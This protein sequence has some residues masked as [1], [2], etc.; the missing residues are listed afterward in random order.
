MPEVTLEGQ[1]KL[2]ASKVLVVGTGGLGSPILAYLSAAGIGQ[3]GLVDFDHVD[4]TNLQ[5][6]I[7]HKT[8][9]VGKPKTASAIET[10]REINP[11]VK[12]VPYETS[13]RSDNAIEIAKEYDVILDGTDNF[14][15]RYLVNDTCALLGKPNVYGSIFRFDGQVSVFWAEK[16]PCY[17]C[18][19]SEP[20]DPGD[21]PS[22]AEG[23]VLGVLPGVV[24]VLQAIE[25]IKIIAGIGDP[26]IGRL[27]VFDA[28]KMRFREMKLR[29]NDACPLCGS[30]PTIT[31]LV[32]YNQFCGT[33]PV[34]APAQKLMALPEL[35]PKQ[36]EE[37]LKKDSSAVLLDVREP[38]EHEI[39]HIPG[40]KLIPLGELS[41]RVHELDT[42]NEIVIYCK[43]EQ[44]TEKAFRQLQ[45]AGF[46]KLHALEG[47][48]EGWAED[49]DPSMPMY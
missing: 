48:I 43:G 7:I 35:S 23:G 19:Y 33:A 16:G 28:L 25:T 30:N 17:R 12:V 29:K 47:G 38:H 24:G 3:L 1:K 10:I 46:K 2:K 41:K 31:E 4:T 37:L 34:D 21:V 6:Q 13:F 18:M 14:A 8:S 39:V 27:L 9:S 49:I 45:Q 22:C 20:P 5:R 11:H 36:T 44:R 26:L 32:D 42:A 40:A 15:T